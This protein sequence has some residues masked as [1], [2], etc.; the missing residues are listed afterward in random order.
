V[1]A[2]RTDVDASGQLGVDRG[3]LAFWV[4]AIRECF[5]EAGVLLAYDQAG[6]VVRFDDDSVADRF[7]AHRHAVDRGKRRLVEV[8]EA[9]RLRLAVDQ[10]YYFSHWITPEGAPR[11][12]DTRFFVTRAPDAQEPL[13]DNREVIANLWIRPADALARSK[14]G[15]FDLI[16]PTMRSLMAL[17]TFATA[18]DLLAHA[19]AINDVSPILPRIVADEGGFR[20]VLPDD[21]EYH[22]VAPAVLPE[23]VPMNKLN[24]PRAEPSRELGD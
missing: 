7:L 14:A 16:F 24:M 8:C 11:R 2:G 22:Q 4:A 6:E 10:I 13:H 17:R 21:P 19:A 18:D 23:G 20:I 1:C 12:Y 3:G 15:E 5:E 9:E